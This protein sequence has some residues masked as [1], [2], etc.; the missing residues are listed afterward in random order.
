MSQLDDTL[1]ALFEFLDGQGL[2]PPTRNVRIV[3]IGSGARVDSRGCIHVHRAQ[4]R[5]IPECEARF[6]ELMRSGMP[7]IN[8]SCYGRHDDYLIVAIELPQSAGRP[9][10]KTSINYSG[11]IAAVLQNGWSA[12]S[13]II[14]E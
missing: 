8:V 13:M 14:I 6:D 5:R 7:W 1:A 3:E 10:M 12:D 11:P 2:V 4:V 9:G